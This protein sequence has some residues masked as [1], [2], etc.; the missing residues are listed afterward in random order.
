M[1]KLEEKFIVIKWDDVH[2]YLTEGDFLLLAK[3]TAKIAEGR[4]A[5]RKPRPINKYY[6]CNQDEPYAKEVINIILG[7]EE[8]KAKKKRKIS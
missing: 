8:R 1:A 3:L 2:K 5:G 4:R 7:G 6:V